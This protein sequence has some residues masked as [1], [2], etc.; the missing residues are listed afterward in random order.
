MKRLPAFA[1]A[2][3]L[4]ATAATARLST[5]SIISP[6]M[7][8]QQGRDVPIWGK[9]APG[10]RITVAY[11]KQRIRTVAAADSAWKALLRPMAADATPRTLAIKGKTE[12]LAY[13]NVVVGE[14]WIASGQSNMAYSMA[15]GKGFAPP[16]RGVDSAAI[17]LEKP[18]NPMIRVFVS[19][20]KGSVQWDEANGNSLRNVSTVGYYFAKSI[21]QSLNVPVGIVKAAVNGTSIEEWTPKELYAAMPAVAREIGGDGKFRGRKVGGRYHKLVEPLAPLAIRGFIWYQGESNCGMGDTLYKEKFK[22]MA[23]LWRRTFDA[24]GAPF[25]YVLIGPHV[26]SGR[27]HRGG[28]PQTAE[29]LPLFRQEQIGIKS[30]VENTDYV[31]ITDLIDDIHDIHP[32]YKWKV[33]ERLARLA[34]NETYGRDSIVCHGPSI[35][36]ARVDGP[37]I[38]VEFTDAAKGLRTNDGKRISWFEVAGESGAFHPAVADIKGDST[39]VVHSEAVPSPVYVRFAWHETAE[40]NLVN[41]LSLPAIPFAATRAKK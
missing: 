26:Y 13:G 14:V 34:L 31:S 37:S 20:P 38:E 33:G 29:T 3:L 27:M 8:L 12:T 6:N 9:A 4:A 22:I 24:P 41:S 16:A 32:S 17:E 25:Y 35:A 7:V 28:Q 11:G 30:M 19:D 18:Q 36:G 39:V 5:P 1:A 40:P 10:E 21:Q 15:R 23:D 2:M